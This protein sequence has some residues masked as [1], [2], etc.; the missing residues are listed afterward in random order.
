MQRSNLSR[1][2]LVMS[3][4]VRASGGCES[5]RDWLQKSDALWRALSATEAADFAARQLQGIAAAACGE[6]P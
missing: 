4:I 5:A 2:Y 1:A 6:K 3:D